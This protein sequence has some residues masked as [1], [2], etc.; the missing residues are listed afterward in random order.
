VTLVKLEA[1]H[2]RR[3]APNLEDR[4]R[5]G[6]SVGTDFCPVTVQ[7]LVQRLDKERHTDRSGRARKLGRFSNPTRTL[8][9]A[10]NPDAEQTDATPTRPF[11]VAVVLVA[12]FAAG[13]AFDFACRPRESAA[14][15]AAT[16]RRHP[17]EVEVCRE[18]AQRMDWLGNVEEQLHDSTDGPHAGNSRIDIITPTH[19]WEADWSHKWP[20]AI[21]QS[22]YYALEWN[23][24]HTSDNRKPG[25]LLLLIDPK[26][27]SHYV[28]RCRRVCDSLGITLKTEIVRGK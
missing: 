16:V 5:R 22:S 24:Q 28:A 27:E 13:I 17:T 19:V 23:A 18:I 6:D 1:D 11:I 10:I 14:P 4:P 21:G 9:T 20:E 25:V 12:S 2:A 15:V 3:F 7:R 26:K 8:A